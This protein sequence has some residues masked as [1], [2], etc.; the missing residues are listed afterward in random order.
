VISKTTPAF[1]RLFNALP[2]DI[3]AQ[4]RDTFVLFTSNPNHPSL[5]Y[6]RIK[7]HK[8]W[9]RSVRIGLNYRAL[10]IE[11][12]NILYWIWIGPRADFDYFIKHY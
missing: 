5:H 2:P 7:R 8:D 11:R 4:A 1:R 3:Q 9:L 12:G 10:A 6:Q